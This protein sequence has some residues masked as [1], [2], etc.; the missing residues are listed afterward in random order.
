VAKAEAAKKRGDAEGVLAATERALAIKPDAEVAI[1]RAEA[2][3]LLERYDE[4][5]K[6]FSRAMVLD[7]NLAAP[8][9]GLG[10]IH[11]LTGEANRAR[12]YFKMYVRSK[13]ADVK[14]ALLRK[15]KAFLAG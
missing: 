4:A 12:Y 13:A 15:A 6:A 11:R 2:L 9:Y 8:F 7:P 14:P 5:K 3:V 10:E 1:L